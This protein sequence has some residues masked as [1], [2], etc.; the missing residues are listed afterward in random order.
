MELRQRAH[1]NEAA[2]YARIIVGWHARMGADEWQRRFGHERDEQER[3]A[4]YQRDVARF[5]D[6]DLSDP[7]VQLAIAKEQISGSM[8]WA[9]G[10]PIPEQLPGLERQHRYLGE[11]ARKLEELASPQQENEHQAEGR[12][13]V[14]Y[15]NREDLVVK[16][17]EIYSAVT[18]ADVQGA[19]GTSFLLSCSLERSARRDDG[20]IVLLSPEIL[21]A[22]S[23]PH[24]RKGDLL[25]QLGTEGL[26]ILDVTGSRS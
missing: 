24:G 5:H 18:G 23:A 26:E 20:E 4:R 25:E 21:G 10:V 6:S 7:A 13:V 8:E 17:R 9:Y 19:G 22:S 14:W 1:N 12:S 2:M 15:S 11:I 3:L 16:A